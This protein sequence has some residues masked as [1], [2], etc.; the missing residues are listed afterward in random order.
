[1]IIGVIL[2][3]Y[4]FALA[5]SPD[6]IIELYWRT[7]IKPLDYS[8]LP[9]HFQILPGYDLNSILLGLTL[10][11]MLFGPGLFFIILGV[12]LYRK[13]SKKKIKFRKPNKKT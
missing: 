12:W 1:M 7:F 9:F 3:Y 13:E 10:L 6:N 4:P 8:G 2:F 5:L 11:I